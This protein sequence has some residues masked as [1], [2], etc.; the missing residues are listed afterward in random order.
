MEKL[1]I[2]VFI[3]LLF[4]GCESTTTKKVNIA[5]KKTVPIEILLSNF[6]EK[7]NITIEKISK[8]N[9]DEFSVESYLWT[10]GTYT[11]INAGIINRREDQ[12]NN[13]FHSLNN[14][15]L[16]KVKNYL[17]QITELRTHY[18]KLKIENNLSTHA[19]DLI[20][21]NLTS[22]VQLTR[23]TQVYINQFEKVGFKIQ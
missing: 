4:I 15:K 12:L 22:I 14:N 3:G 6:L 9:G 2:S 10:T 7:R 21:K 19:V 16:V 23:L 18:E 13:L 20:N 1:I 8:W 11:E 17:T 5:N